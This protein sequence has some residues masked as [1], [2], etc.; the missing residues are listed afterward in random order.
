[1]YVSTKNTVICAFL[2]GKASTTLHFRAESPRS[3]WGELFLPN[4]PDNG[5]VPLPPRCPSVVSYEE[6]R[7][8]PHMA[9]V[10]KTAGEHPMASG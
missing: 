9:V 1:M 4:Q 7:W 5:D 8:V 10:T 6:R 3:G 2:E